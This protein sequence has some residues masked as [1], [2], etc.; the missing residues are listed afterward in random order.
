MFLHT[1]HQ[2]LTCS[3]LDHTKNMDGLLN[4][5]KSVH[6]MSVVF[7]IKFT[8]AMQ[9]WFIRCGGCSITIFLQ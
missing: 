9:N 6:K 4:T 8:V 2:N 7:I 1:I 3:D 5:L